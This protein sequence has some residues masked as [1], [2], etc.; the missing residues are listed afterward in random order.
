MTERF[1]ADTL[2]PCYRVV[3]VEPSLEPMVS[4]CRYKSDTAFSEMCRLLEGKDHATIQQ[5]QK[6]ST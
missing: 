5:G 3:V 2:F 6:V 1:D 4:G